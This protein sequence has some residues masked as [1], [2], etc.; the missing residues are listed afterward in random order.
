MSDNFHKGFKEYIIKLYFEKPN[1]I[2]R[3]KFYNNDL[4]KFEDELFPPKHI[5]TDYEQYYIIIDNNSEN[6]INKILN[7]E[8]KLNCSKINIVYISDNKEIYIKQNRLNDKIFIYNVSMKDIVE[9][10]A[11]KI[12]VE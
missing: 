11:D 5:T 4:N 10:A 7:E 6:I 8:Q 2:N 9:N 3:F 12:F 1:K